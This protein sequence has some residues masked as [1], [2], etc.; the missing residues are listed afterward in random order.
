VYADT[1][2]VAEARDQYL[3]DNGF[4]LAGYSDRWVTLKIGPFPLALPN[5]TSRRAAVP[6]HD[7]HHVA[8]GYPT[9]WVGEIEIGAWELAAGCGRHWA[10]WGFNLGAMAVGVF[11]APRRLVRAFVRGWH[12]RSLYDRQFGTDLLALSVGELRDRLKLR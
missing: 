3:R 6:L 1:M 12:C 4:T 11:R 5:T 2:T 7:L 9:T 10:A 8:T